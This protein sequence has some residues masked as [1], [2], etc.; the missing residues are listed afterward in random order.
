LMWKYSKRISQK[1]EEMPLLSPRSLIQPTTRRA[2]LAVR[3]K[4]R[5][6]VIQK[7][8][9]RLAPARRWITAGKQLVLSSQ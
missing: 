6:I 8:S 9:G 3:G 4:S 2:N 5:Y 7:E 1:V